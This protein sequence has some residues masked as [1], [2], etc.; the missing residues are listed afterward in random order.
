MLK[1]VGGRDMIKDHKEAARRKL[2]KILPRAALEL[3]SQ[4]ERAWSLSMSDLVCKAIEHWDV[5]EVR[6]EVDKIFRRAC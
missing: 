4:S 3:L 5:E 6:I 1:V 2:L